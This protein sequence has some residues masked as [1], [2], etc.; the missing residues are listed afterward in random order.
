M[1]GAARTTQGRPHVLQ[2]AHR[3]AAWHS[4]PPPQHGNGTC[5][6]PVLAVP[7]R[8]TRACRR[9]AAAAVAC[10]PALHVSL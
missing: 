8:P 1:S 3:A 9:R 2:Q 6:W 4:C 5:T 7:H 10:V